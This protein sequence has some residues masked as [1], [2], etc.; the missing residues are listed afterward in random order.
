[1]NERW[2]ERL[3]MLLVRFSYL[4]MGAD[5]PSQSIN[6]LWSIYLYLSRLAEG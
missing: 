1:M 5:I 4:G 3:E 6:E 2:L